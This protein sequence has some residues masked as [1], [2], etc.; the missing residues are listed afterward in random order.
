MERYL[1]FARAEY[2][3]PLEHRGEVEAAG[4]EAAARLARERY[5]E[6]WLEMS[7]V[8]VSKAYWAEK[9]TEE[10]EAEVQV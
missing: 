10:G 8:P 2:D 3:Q 7:L 6:D 1:V 5:G 4:D 9:E